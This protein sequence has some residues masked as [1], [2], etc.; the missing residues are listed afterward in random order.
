M[1]QHGIER[2]K[3]AAALFI[4]CCLLPSASVAQGRVVTLVGTIVDSASGQPLEKVAVYIPDDVRTDTRRDGT[5]RLRFVPDET[6]LI[7]FR[8][9]GYSPR[10]IRMSLQGREGREIDL[11]D[12]VMKEAAVTLD[13]ITV[14]T[15]LL[16][17]NPRLT[18]FYRRKRQGRGL[19]FSREDILRIQPMV[20][21]DLVR[22]VPGLTVGCQVLASCIPAS[23][24]KTAMGDVTCPMR[25]LL[26]GVPTAIELDLI[27]PAWIAGVEVYKSMALTPLELSTAGTVGVG[28]PG[29][30]TLVIWTGADD[31][32]Q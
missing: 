29:C 25:V 11:G 22:R 6:S 26:D 20:A 18:D 12:I 9:I 23:F 1:R 10:A 21:T 19:Y 30:G 32:E 7:L 3:T 8:K 27:P 15:R 13:P 28:N 16:S 24:R 31:Y 14:E 2:V 17:R 5:F 4:A